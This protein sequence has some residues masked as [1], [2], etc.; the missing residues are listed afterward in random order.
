[1]F[2]INFVDEVFTIEQLRDELLASG[3]ANLPTL[4]GEC[5][6]PDDV[7]HL[8]CA[9]Q[10]RQIQSAQPRHRPIPIRVEG[11]MLLAFEDAVAVFITRYQPLRRALDLRPVAFKERVVHRHLMFAKRA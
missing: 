8:R 5:G 6:I 3:F 2:R 11:V 9:E 4:R 10:R 7:R 1:M